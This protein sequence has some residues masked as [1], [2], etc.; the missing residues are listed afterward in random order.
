MTLCRV[1][2]SEHC[3]MIQLIDVIKKE[4]KVNYGERQCMNKHNRNIGVP[5][6]KGY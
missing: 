6:T 3:T 4:N 5:I 1:L 2:Q